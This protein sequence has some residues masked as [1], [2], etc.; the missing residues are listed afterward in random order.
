MQALK[1]GMRE[2]RA[3]MADYI[4]SNTAVAITR[5]GQ[6][7]GYFIPAQNPKD[8]SIAALRQ[9]GKTMAKLLEDHGISEEEI[10]AEFE[11]LR[12]KAKKKSNG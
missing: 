3:D 7:I 9:A 2:F 1:V 6:T 5:H 12:K 4:N 10:V 11:A 8:E